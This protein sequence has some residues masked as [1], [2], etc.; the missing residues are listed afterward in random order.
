MFVNGKL[1]VAWMTERV[2]TAVENIETRAGRDIVLSFAFIDVEDEII[3]NRFWIIT[4][5]AIN[6]EPVSS[7]ID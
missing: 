7:Y 4:I 1:F 3:P 5:M 6:G 2:I